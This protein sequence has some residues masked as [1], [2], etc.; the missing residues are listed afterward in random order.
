MQNPHVKISIVINTFNVSEYINRTIFSVLSQLTNETEL[1]I[2]DD[3]STDD[4]VTRIKRSLPNDGNIHFIAQ[5][6]NKGISAER[7]QGILKATGKYIL[8]ID[9]DDYIDSNTIIKLLNII[10]KN[11]YD[12][13]GFNMESVPDYNSGKAL[14]NREKRYVSSELEVG[15]YTK[16]SLLDNLFRGELKH[17]PTSY[18]FKR[19]VFLSNAISF[20]DNINYGED[21]ATIYKF[22]N[23]VEIGAVIND[24]FYK[25]V[26][27]NSSATHKPQLKYAQDNLQVSRK[28]L[29]YFKNTKYYSGARNY[30][31]PRLITA[32]SIATKV[33]SSDSKILI[34]EIEN[35]IKLLSKSNYDLKK[36]LSRDL[37]LKIHLNNTGLLKYIY[38]CK[39]LK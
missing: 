35:E 37:R 32:L 18:L 5:A 28:I 7:N 20:P 39:G 24:R 36:Y 15:I 6:N 1:I 23:F 9:G 2:I 34:R 33:N 4:T 29:R 12:I 3:G 27:R 16:D 30:V 8:F 22:F 11:D 19:Q 14:S 21:Y 13:V 10:K 38:Y 31:I 17:N 25:Y 26:Q